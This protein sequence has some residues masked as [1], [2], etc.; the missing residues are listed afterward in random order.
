MGADTTQQR[1]LQPPV[2]CW[3]CQAGFAGLRPGG[4]YG[5]FV[6]GP[7][8]GVFRIPVV[9]TGYLGGLGARF[10]PEILHAEPRRSRG[11]LPPGA[12]RSV[13]SKSCQSRRRPFPLLRSLPHPCGHFPT[14]VVTSPLVWS[15]PH[16]SGHIPTRLVTSPPVYGW[17]LYSQV[18]ISHFGWGCGFTG[19]D[20]TSP[21]PGYDRTGGSSL[22]PRRRGAGRPGFPHP[23]ECRVP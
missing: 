23:T 14:R 21:E 10:R 19:G 2:V 5:D 13:L 15:H 16:P 3:T 22:S 9:P 11:E 6:F 1:H 8:R 17:G 4:D 12:T 18:E 7:N 20:V